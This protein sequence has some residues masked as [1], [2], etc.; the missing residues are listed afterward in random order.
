PQ[1][2]DLG[3]ATA[4]AERPRRRVPLETGLRP[5]RLPADF[6]LPGAPRPAKLAA[7][8]ATPIAVA[9]AP[10]P[11]A[12]PAPRRAQ[13]AGAVA[14][15]ARH[16]ET[17]EQFL[18]VQNEVMGRYLGARATGARAGVTPAVAATPVARPPLPLIQ[19]VA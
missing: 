6:A 8:E 12:P 2:V 11:P 19:T 16:F 15:L 1:T 13:P 17:M 3:A 5:L 7:T 9:A 14:A 10:A 4:A 18:R